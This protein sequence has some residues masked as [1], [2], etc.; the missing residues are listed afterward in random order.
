MQQII[1]TLAFM[2]LLIA[3]VSAVDRIMDK[4]SKKSLGYSI[5]A[6]ITGRQYDVGEVRNPISFIERIKPFSLKSA[7]VSAIFSTSAIIVVVYIQY[8]ALDYNFS[9]IAEG[10]SGA[11]LNVYLLFLGYMVLANAIVDYVSFTQ[12][13]VIIRLINKTDSRKSLF[14]LLF[15][16]LLASINIFTFTYA[17]FLVWGV[18]SLLNFHE[19]GHF[20]VSIEESAPSAQIT[21]MMG[22]L[23][24]SDPDRFKNVS[25]LRVTNSSENDSSSLVEAYI[26]GAKPA[27][28]GLVFPVLKTVLETEFPTSSMLLAQQ[29]GTI[30]PYKSYPSLTVDYVFKG[31]MNFDLS[32]P[33]FWSHWFSA[34]YLLTDDVQDNFF[35]VTGLSPGFQ[36]VDRLRSDASTRVAEMSLR[37]L[38]VNWCSTD[39][40]RREK[41]DT[42]CHDGFVFV[43]AE[44]PVLDTKLAIATNVGGKLPLY[45][46]F[47]TSLSLTLVIYLFYLSIYIF[48]VAWLAAGS[49]SLPLVRFANFDEHPITILSA[50]I[51]LLAGLLYLLLSG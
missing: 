6:R 18:T 34:A 37:D 40:T 48:K 13:L 24:F 14:V 35:A 49:L 43:S 9:E 1:P 4:E 50:P 27:D 28:A 47:F 30:A 45:T 32:P 51:I 12:T 44:V 19:R 2:G 25:I 38:V 7:L 8:F 11:H 20:V 10:V 31:S 15:T 33:S 29:A 22:A 41:N 36:A 17:F 21:E 26:L 16:D 46:F 42:S 23:G 39:Q 3:L 5:K